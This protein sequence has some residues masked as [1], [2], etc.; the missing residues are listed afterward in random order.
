M[1]IDFNETEIKAM[2]AFFRGDGEDGNALQDTFLA[3]L[4]AARKEGMDHCP[5][6]DATCKHHGNCF[7]CVQ[8]H[9]GHGMHL[10][11]CMHLMVNKRLEAVSEL[12]EHTI[13]RQ[14]KVPDY[15]PDP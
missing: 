12:S 10:P 7:E 14:V 8:I 11:A 5:C 2:E 13:V 1:K 9:R 15:V 4:K 3:Q 6:K